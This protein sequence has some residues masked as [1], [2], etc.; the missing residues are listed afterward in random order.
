MTQEKENRLIAAYPHLFQNNKTNSPY[1]HFGVECGDGWYQLIN[2]LC[3][4]ICEVD[5][6]KIVRVAQIKEKFA[7]LRFHV[8]IGADEE[9]KDVYYNRRIFNIILKYEGLS[10]LICEQCGSTGSTATTGYWIKT[11]CDNCINQS[12]DS[13]RPYRRK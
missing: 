5:T 10:A 1:S 9:E 7:S 4:D 12:R 3:K 2:D 13:D 6:R 11:M 8:D